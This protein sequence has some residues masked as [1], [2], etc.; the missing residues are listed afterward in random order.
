MY[1]ICFAQI[2]RA[3]GLNN[4]EEAVF[5]YF[6][7]HMAKNSV[8][9]QGSSTGSLPAVPSGLSKRPVE[10]LDEMAMEIVK[11]CEGRE[12]KEVCNCDS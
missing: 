7:D 5:D 2:A 8:S 6:R 10:S 9:L 11:C 12:L 4:F 3:T 1:S